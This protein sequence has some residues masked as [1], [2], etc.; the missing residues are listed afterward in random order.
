[1]GMSLKG[2]H[3]TCYTVTQPPWNGPIPFSLYTE[4]SHM[5]SQEQMSQVPSTFIPSRHP[6]GK[7]NFT[8]PRSPLVSPS[9]HYPLPPGEVPSPLLGTD[10]L[11]RLWSFTQTA[12]HPVLA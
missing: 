5:F 4:T 9:R 12:P 11:C 8:S 10:Q 6:G 2:H 3:P 7:Q 1:M